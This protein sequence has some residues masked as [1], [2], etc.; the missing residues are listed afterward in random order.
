[1]VL[2]F[3][4]GGLVGRVDF[5]EEHCTSDGVIHVG[6]NSSVA[7]LQQP[8]ASANSGFPVT[9]VCAKGLGRFCL[10]TAKNSALR[11]LFVSHPRGHT[12]ELWSVLF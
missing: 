7:Q 9:E 4:F 11:L 10:M 8:L 6:V 12:L 3:E 2:T 5:W 1:V